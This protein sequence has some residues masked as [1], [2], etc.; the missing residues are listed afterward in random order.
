MGVG[1]LD[2]DPDLEH[3]AATVLGSA[4]HKAFFIFLGGSKLLG[5][6]GLWGQGIFSKQLSYVAL[7]TPAA[8]A[9]Y[10]HAK[11]DDGKAIFAAGYLV[12]LSALIFLENKPSSFPDN[13]NKKK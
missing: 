7:G 2:I 3:I 10:G 11:V 4:P 1:A 5:A 9:I 13:S 6:L 12:A 8:C